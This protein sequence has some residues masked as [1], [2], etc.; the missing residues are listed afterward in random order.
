VREPNNPKPDCIDNPTILVEVTSP[1]TKDY[2]YGTKREMYF[3]LPSLQ[4]YL[5]VSQ[6]E[7]L[8]GHY[9]R[10][11]DGWMYVDRGADG[12]IVLDDVQVQVEKI[13]AGILVSKPQATGAAGESG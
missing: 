2:D 3:S 12:V 10:S 7:R 11:G 9:R 13:Y 1:K 4:H 5:L 6:T 8:V